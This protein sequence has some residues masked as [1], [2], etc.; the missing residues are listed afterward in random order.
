MSV[1]FYVCFNIQLI[2]P[3]W[4]LSIDILFLIVMLTHQFSNQAST[5]LNF[6]FRQ[7]KHI[8]MDGWTG[9]ANCKGCI[10]LY[11]LIIRLFC[12]PCTLWRKYFGT[13]TKWLYKPGFCTFLYKKGEGSFSFSTFA[14]MITVNYS[15]HF[16]FWQPLSF[17]HFSS[18]SSFVVGP[19][20]VYAS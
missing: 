14:D 8:C 11:L 19:T 18:I 9:K 16:S 20:I 4:S 10:I 1:G 17:V 13:C 7:L 5:S 2:N 12:I 15:V 3:P 6:F